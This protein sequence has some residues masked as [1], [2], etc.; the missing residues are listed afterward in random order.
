[1]PN[2]ELSKI[3][4]EY[5]SG[6]RPAKDV[7]AALPRP[8]FGEPKELDEMADPPGGVGEGTW[9]EV[10]HAFHMGALTI[11]QYRELYALYGRNPKV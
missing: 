8:T 6:L 3:I 1:M 11:E 10:A 7:V 4:A 5:A 9:D 2:T